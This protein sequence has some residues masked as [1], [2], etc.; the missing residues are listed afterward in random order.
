[1][2]NTKTV[3][4]HDDKGSS[5]KSKT[6]DTDSNQPNDR[7]ISAQLTFSVSGNVLSIEDAVKLSNK[8]QNDSKDQEDSVVPKKKRQI[9]D[10]SGKTDGVTNSPHLISLQSYDSDLA[11]MKT[12]IKAQLKLVRELKEKFD[13]ENDALKEVTLCV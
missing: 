10:N 12:H 3:D 2:K 1:M 9:A 7:I 8:R 11:L 13:R 6:S 5:L 4:D